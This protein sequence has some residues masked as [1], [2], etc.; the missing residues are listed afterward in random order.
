MNQFSI[1]DWEQTDEGMRKGAVYFFCRI[2]SIGEA[3]RQKS[4]LSA[5][6]PNLT[7]HFE[8]S[9]KSEIPRVR[10]G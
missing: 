5:L 1:L 6:F 8:R 3:Y 4:C 2:A 9:E 7:C 10:S